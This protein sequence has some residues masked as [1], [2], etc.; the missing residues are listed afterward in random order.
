[1]PDYVD[2]LDPLLMPPVRLLGATMLADL[3]WRHFATIAD[4][5]GVDRAT[6]ST[7][8][9]RLRRAGYLEVRRD[10]NRTLWRLTN[11]GHER[12]ADHL[13]AL[14]DVIIRAGQLARDTRS[15]RTPVPA[16]TGSASPASVS[17]GRHA[18]RE[19]RG[20]EGLSS[21]CT[22]VTTRQHP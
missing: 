4:A 11:H 5:I 15:R 22:T 16:G 1:M 3:R 14:R 2:S 13:D 20:R 8:F 7:D 12:L 18:L 6:L 19:T 10:G 9:R 21:S 17:A